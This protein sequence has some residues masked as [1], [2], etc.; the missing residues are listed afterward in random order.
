MIRCL[1]WLICT[2]SR[3]YETTEFKPNKKRLSFLAVHALERARLQVTDGENIKALSMAI[4][5][6]CA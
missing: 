3:V 4:P 6:P 1:G 5:I 2:M